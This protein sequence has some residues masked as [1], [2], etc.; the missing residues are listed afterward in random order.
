MRIFT[1]SDL[2]IDFKSNENWLKQLSKSDH[3]DDILILAGDISHNLD[4]FETT[5]IELKSRFGFIFFVPGNH[6]LW[7]SPSSDES[8]KDKFYLLIDIC[9]RL[10]IYTTPKTIGNVQIIPLLSWYDGSFGTPGSKLLECWGDYWMCKWPDE[11]R[12]REVGDFFHSQNEPFPKK[13]SEMCITF[14]HFMP[15]IDLLPHIINPATYFL[16]PV[17]GSSI[18]EKQIRKLSPDLHIYGHSHINRSQKLG[19]ITYINNAMGYPHETYLRKTLKEVS[20]ELH[21]A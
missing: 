2:H 19:G 5:L 12:D 10:N 7:V 4:Q 14:S 6:D 15:R 9:E 1:I 16:S 18:L 13:E 11:M 3:Q 21:P 8:S 20:F 17:L